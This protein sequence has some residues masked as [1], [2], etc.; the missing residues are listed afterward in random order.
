MSTTQLPGVR[1]SHEDVI[2]FK[3]GILSSVYKFV[4]WLE[5]DVKNQIEYTFF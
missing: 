1:L 2:V 4:H 3:L 5:S